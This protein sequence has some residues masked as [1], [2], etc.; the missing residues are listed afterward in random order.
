MKDE[1]QLASLVLLIRLSTTA[2]SQKTKNEHNDGTKPSSVEDASQPLSSPLQRALEENDCK[3]LF[4]I[5]RLIHAYNDSVACSNAKDGDTKITTAYAL[6]RLAIHVIF[7]RY[8]EDISGI[9]YRA[10]TNGSN[11]NRV[12]QCEQYLFRKLLPATLRARA[13]FDLEEVDVEIALIMRCLLLRYSQRQGPV[14]L[15]GK[16]MK[17]KSDCCGELLWANFI[18]ALVD[19][20]VCRGEG[21]SLSPLQNATTTT[22]IGDGDEERLMVQ[23]IHSILDGGAQSNDNGKT[24]PSDDNSSDWNSEFNKVIVGCIQTFLQ[25]ANSGGGE[26][27]FMLKRSTIF[28]MIQFSQQ[29]DAMSVHVYVL[30]LQYLQLCM[31]STKSVS[32]FQKC[33]TSQDIGLNDNESEEAIV[34][35]I[36]SFAFYGLVVLGNTVASSMSNSNQQESDAPPQISMKGLRAKIYT[37]AMDLWRSFGPDWLFYDSHAPSSSKLNNEFW[38]FRSKNTENQLGLTW[39]LCTL[40]QL[41]AGDLRLNLG[42]WVTIVED[43][44]TPSQDN[45]YVCS[46]IESCATVILETVQLMTSLAD[47]E[48]EGIASGVWVPEALLHIRKS[49]EDAL[50]S[51]VQYLNSFSGDQDETRNEVSDQA[52]NVGRICCMLIGTIASELEVEDLLISPS[53]DERNMQLTKEAET[54]CFAS[55]LSAGML[56]CNAV[57]EKNVTNAERLETSEP[58]CCLLPCIMSVI[59]CSSSNERV[60]TAVSSLNDSV[61]Y[62]MSQFLHRIGVR[63]NHLDRWSQIDESFT[64]L[65]IAGLS[66]LI[67]EELVTSSAPREEY[68]ELVPPLNLWKEALSKDVEDALE[69]H[70]DKTLQQVGNCLIILKTYQ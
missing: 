70:V 1:Q 38:W 41:V 60:E 12:D 69:E 36:R 11:N 51:S 22:A 3:L 37:L 61:A 54:S 40:V 5:G 18:E 47:D 68:Q 53:I 56:L 24:K 64:I 30:V 42:R 63:W 58:L 20:R 66:L 65:S 28:E 34:A 27:S 26:S 45:E 4:F 50:N 52:I 8:T 10:A 6:L 62:V 16:Q 2:S 55:A 43:G 21:T 25:H 14:I 23:T 35:S 59:A 9:N 15:D 57:G 46:E 44:N 29:S 19:H 17:K 48:G 67:I 13:S 32:S 7:L 33:F 49:L 39:P 31:Q